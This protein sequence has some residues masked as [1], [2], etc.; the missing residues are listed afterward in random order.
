MRAE[1]GLES[2]GPTEMQ[3]TTKGRDSQEMQGIEED[4][5]GDTSRQP[6]RCS[7]SHTMGKLVGIS[8][9]CCLC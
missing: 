4:R 1:G 9:F 6:C 5:E 7:A 8:A 3:G 2:W